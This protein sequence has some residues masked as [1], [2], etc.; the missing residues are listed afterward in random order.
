MIQEYDDVK[1]YFIQ[2]LKLFDSQLLLIVVEVPQLDAH[3]LKV[4]RFKFPKF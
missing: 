2:L 3:L 1:F 4:P